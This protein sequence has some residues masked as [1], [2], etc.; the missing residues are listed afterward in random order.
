MR[1]DARAVGRL[2]FGIGLSLTLAQSAS[3]WGLQ[4]HYMIST[5]ATK[6]LPDSLP[7]FVRSDAA[8]AEIG[9]LGPELDRSKGAGE[10]HDLD[11]DPNHYV[12]FDDN[13]KVGG[14]DLDALPGSRR[15]YD[16]ALRKE[17]GNEYSLGS[18][19]YALEDG[20][21]QVRVDFAMWRVD[22]VGETKAA[23]APDRAW[24]ATARAL[25]EILT[26]R[27]IGVWSHYVGDASQPLHTTI[28]FNG[29]G[30]YPNPGGYSDARDLH[31]RFESTFVRAHATLADVSA[32]M[33]PY[34]TCACTIQRHIAQYLHATLSQVI[35]LY[36]IDKRG[37]FASG[38]PEAVDFV[39]ARLGDGATML[40]DLIV[41]AWEE[42][43]NVKVGYPRGITPKEAEAGSAVPTRSLYGD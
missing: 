22:R 3:A 25:R 19:P 33:R 35:P 10:P 18:L 2:V 4:G 31:S 27:D 39:R 16:T 38:S 20:W 5:A 37:G 1:R 43:A 8:V 34:K 15:D 36:E 28:H 24:F 6:A 32:H 21:E 9:A 42:S 7:A 12:D 26:L 11:L 41:D 17:G 14:V 23:T 13:A 30:K 29:W 40:R